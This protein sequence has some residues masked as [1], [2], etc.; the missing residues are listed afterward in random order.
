MI[1]PQKSLNIAESEKGDSVPAKA[2]VADRQKMIKTKKMR[3]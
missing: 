1:S 3:M 2:L